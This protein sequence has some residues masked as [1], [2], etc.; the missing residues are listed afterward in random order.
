MTL[1][2]EEAQGWLDEVTTAIIDGRTDSITP[3][4]ASAA[5]AAALLDIAD[6]IREQT[7]AEYERHPTPRQRKGRA[8]S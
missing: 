7:A 5:I 6:A 8:A 2:R 3:I 1:N 4:L